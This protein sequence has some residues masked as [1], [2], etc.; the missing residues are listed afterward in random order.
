MPSYTYQ[1][2]QCQIL[3]IKNWTISEYLKM[4]KQKLQCEICN[5]GVLSQQVLSI[6]SAIEQNQDQILMNIQTEIQDIV[7]KVKSGDSRSIHD[8]YGDSPNPYK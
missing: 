8:I 3:N 1:C 4:K 5:S 7:E 2:S 6:N